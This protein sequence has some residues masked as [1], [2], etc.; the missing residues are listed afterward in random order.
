MVI[1]NT[2]KKDSEINFEKIIQFSWCIAQLFTGELFWI[3]ISM[4]SLFFLIFF[5][6]QVVS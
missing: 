2:E 4:T 3:K 1:K 5:R 6:L